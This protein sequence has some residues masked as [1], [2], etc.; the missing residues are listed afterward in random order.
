MSLLRDEIKRVLDLEQR[1]SESLLVF[2]T[3]VAERAHQISD[4]DFDALHPEVFP[5]LNSLVIAIRSIPLAPLREDWPPIKLES[6]DD[7]QEV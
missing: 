7:A 6:L 3:K 1:P 2:A 4:D 5:Y